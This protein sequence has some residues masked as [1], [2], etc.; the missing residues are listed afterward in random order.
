MLDKSVPFHTIIM[1]RPYI[2]PPVIT[3]IP[4]GFKIKSYENENDEIGWAEIEANVLEFESIEE[5][6]NCHK[7]YLSCVDE[8]KKRQVIIKEKDLVELQLLRCLKHF[9][10]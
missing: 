1:K 9:M 10:N 2:K 7:G 3:N 6:A 8:L 5:A 4:E